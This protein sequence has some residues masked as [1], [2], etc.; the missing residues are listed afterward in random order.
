MLGSGACDA[1]Y[2]Q[3]KEFCLFMI[4]VTGAQIFPLTAFLFAFWVSLWHFLLCSF[5]FSF[6]SITGSVSYEEHCLCAFLLFHA[7]QICFFVFSWLL[8]NCCCSFLVWFYV[9][10]QTYSTALALFTKSSYSPS[11][12]WNSKT[13]NLLSLYL[14][15]VSGF[16]IF[17]MVCY[18][19][20]IKNFNFI[21]LIF[22]SVF[23]TIYILKIY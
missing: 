11:A 6:E 16:F 3:P 18:E 5:W 2:R 8:F 21:F 17:P 9:L 23:Q 20:W 1:L 4:S 14:H 15:L 22:I 13:S 12:F 19:V 7:L 10:R